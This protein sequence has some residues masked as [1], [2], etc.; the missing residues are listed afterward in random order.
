MAV[1]VRLRIEAN[2]KVIETSALVNTGFETETPQLLLP[3]EA[4][5]ELGLTK[6]KMGRRDY[7]TPG[8]LVKLYVLPSRARVRV[9]GKTQGQ[10]VEADLVISPFEEEVLI[11]D[12]LT[13]ALGIALE[14]VALGTWRLKGETQVHESERPQG[15]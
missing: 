14:N 4:A 12:K 3:K 5:K 15:W 9:V 8:G 13:E 6:R 11:S 7:L 1:R 10:E 2:E